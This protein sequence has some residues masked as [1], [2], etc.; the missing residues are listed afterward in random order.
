[1][2]GKKQISVQLLTLE[3]IAATYSEN[4]REVAQ[5]LFHY[6]HGLEY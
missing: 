6:T 3:G 4:M 5:K 2:D 1:M